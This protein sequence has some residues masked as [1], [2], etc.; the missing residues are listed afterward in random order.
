MGSS[1]AGS[2]SG[3]S[4]PTLQ[5]KGSTGS[6]TERTFRDQPP[7]Q[8]VP[9]APDA[10][11]VP[12][13]PKNI[14]AIP[15]KSHRRAASLE[16][17]PMRVAS[18]PPNKA[19]GRGSSLGPGTTAQPPRRGGQR[20]TSLSSVQELTGV[21]RPD[22]RGSVNFSYPTGSRPTSPIAQRRLTS[23]SPS[24]ANSPRITS[25]NQNMI[26]DPNSRRFIPAHEYYAIEYA[27]EQRI[28]DAANR[29]VKKKKKVAPQQFTGTHLADGTIGGRPKG[30]AV[31]AMEARASQ[32]NPVE[33]PPPAPPPAPITAPASTLEPIATTPK[34]KRKKRV[35]VTSD[36]DSDQASFMPNSSADESDIQTNGFN[37]REGALLAKKPSIVREDREREE[38]EDDTPQVR[39]GLGKLDALARSI[40]PSSLPH[41]TAGRGHGRGEALAS[42]AFAQ[43]RQHSPAPISP[44]S[45]PATDGLTAKGSVRVQSVSPV[46]TTHFATTPDSL[47]V[48][49][50]PPPRSISPR[51]SALKRS[52]SPRGPS[53]ADD[54]SNTGHVQDSSEMSNGS[55]ATSDEL[56]LPRKKAVRVSFDETNVVVGQAAAPVTTDSPVAQSPQQAKK[57]WF[58]SIGR[59]KKKDMSV[60]EDNDDEVMK[61]RPA[62]PSFGSVR[63][64]KDNREPVEER[65]LVK[66][67]ES[68]DSTP[69]A[70][71]SPPLFANSAGEAIEF[72][73]GLSN[74]HKVGAILSQDA[75]SKNAANISKSREPL[76]PQVLSVEGS[77]YSSDTD[78][79]VSDQKS[80]V[81]VAHDT[82]PVEEVRP[83][84]IEIDPSAIDRDSQTSTPTEFKSGGDVPEIAV[85]QATPTL[86]HS[87]VREWP[88]MPGG[89]NGSSASDSGSTNDETSTVVEHTHTCPT[90]PATI[91]IA[92]PTPAEVQP[93]SPVLGDVAAEDTH[94][95]PAIMEET[96]ESDT[97][98]Y[99]D[100]AEDLSDGDGDGFQSL[101]AVVDSPIVASAVPGLAVTTPP[102]SPTVIIAKERA[103]KSQLS[104]KSSEPDL[105]EGWGKAQEY[106]KGLSAEK[107]RQLEQEARDEA[108]ATEESDSTIEVKPAPKPKKKK[109]VAVLPATAEVPILRQPTPNE[110][111]YMIQPGSKAEPDGHT[112]IM[113]SSM[114]A[115]L[116]STTQDP[117]IRKSMRGPGA[118]RGSMRNEETRGSLSKK[119]RPVSLPAPKADQAAVNMHVRN[120]SAASAA[121]AS[122]AAQRDMAA[123]PPPALRRKSSG[124]SDSSF[125]RARKSTEGSSMRR[126]MRTSANEH[127]QSPVRPSRFSLRSLSPT[128]SAYRKPFN[129]AVA[130]SA[131]QTHMRQSLRGSVGATPS[132]RGPKPEK[133]SR[134]P[135][136]GRSSSTKPTPKP[137]R[138]RSSRF[139]DSSDEED[140]RPAFRSRF[141]DSDSDDDDMPTPQSGGFGAGTM[142]T[143]APIRG[144]PKRRGVEDGDSSD[145]PDSDDE[146]KSPKLPLSP[147]LKLS[148]NRQNGSAATSGAQ[149]MSLAS[150]SLR[151]SGSGRET[152]GSPTTAITATATPRPPNNRRGSFMNIL[153]RKKPDPNSKVRKSDAESP[154]R[155][156]TPLERSKFD[157]QAVKRQESYAS[158][159]ADR[160]STPKLQKKAPGWPLVSDS[161]HKIIGDEDGRPYTAG[162]GDGV[163]SGEAGKVENRIGEVNG[164]NGVNG[165]GRPDIG[166]SRFTATG[167]G[168]V[169]LNGVGKGR[170]KK[171][172]GALR[173]MFRLD[174]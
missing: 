142:R 157:L 77:G 116:P 156:D 6:M 30:T 170:K 102:E 73:L 100:A 29:P 163:V 114:H 82:N 166:T 131:S 13:I 159:T 16:N 55:T 109:K 117:H 135:G 8:A 65:P 128:G 167:L 61:P 91:G 36:S 78:S 103:Y 87:D 112:S 40:S 68:V 99:S 153:K 31:D 115:G 120:L 138:Q 121:A 26:Y 133:S 58:S 143:N 101:D 173:R 136:F 48:K 52:N 145:L 110:R 124:D 17:P 81:A 18:P 54:A 89:W 123:K 71:P 88:D 7:S 47:V 150:G 129:S 93:H 164:V 50:Q 104:K 25:S 97:S 34:K 169:D 83:V 24:R 80:P 1:I 137:I 49:H 130:P 127:Q 140:M 46:R 107:K 165:D 141:A 108:D 44:V 144:I 85:L 3:G 98:V 74:D 60:V 39:D 148:K 149:G 28:Q 113:R 70:L 33:Q 119:N 158:T 154:A 5:R 43:E 126:S 92:E 106:W 147:G 66:P 172:F 23:P 45:T 90:T 22:S 125:K 95:I 72:P 171:K 96:E 56:S 53:P 151:R 76:P 146:K 111:S 57:S 84:E 35:V 62:L 37:T 38:E 64:K 94:T 174:D 105:D 59:G 21:E 14:P 79:S 152:M 41:S 51:K 139:A 132:M 155:R 134:I 69:P 4:R 168:G 10:P 161:P 162:A 42:A 67:A 2:V 118:M 12:A 11:P 9:S 86:E 20:I 63:G 27:I 75:S 19:N 160:P 32:P 122:G 15:P